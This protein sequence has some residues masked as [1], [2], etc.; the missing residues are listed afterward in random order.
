MMKPNVVIVDDEHVIREGLARVLSGNY[1]THQISNGHEAIDLVRNDSD[2]DVVLCDLKMP[3][4]DGVE[5]IERI[6]AE[7][8]DIYII[9]ITAAPPQLVC[10]AMKMGANAFM[11]KPLDI[12][13]LEE[14]IE[15]AIRLKKAGTYTVSSN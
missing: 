6:R 1:I 7:N 11:C 5:V 12:D 13:Q 4:I 8:K 9:V 2:I 10:N 3:E 14:R 15:N